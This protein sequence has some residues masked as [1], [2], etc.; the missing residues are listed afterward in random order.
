MARYTIKKPEELTMDILRKRFPLDN[1]TKSTFNPRELFNSRFT[2]KIIMTEII[3]F[4]ESNTVMNS[5]FM[6]NY[7][8]Q[9]QNL[10]GQFLEIALHIDKLYIN[11]NDEDF[12][13]SSLTNCIRQFKN[14]YLVKWCSYAFRF[15]SNEDKLVKNYIGEPSVYGLFN[16]SYM[17]KARDLYKDFGDLLH[18][19]YPKQHSL[20]IP[21][22]NGNIHPTEVLKSLI[23]FEITTKFMKADHIVGPS[24]NTSDIVNNFLHNRK[25]KSQTIARRI[26]ELQQHP[27]TTDILMS[28]QSL[29]N[30]KLVQFNVEYDKRKYDCVDIRKLEPLIDLIPKL[31]DKKKKNESTGKIKILDQAECGYTFEELSN[32][33]FDIAGSAGGVNHIGHELS[34]FINDTNSSSTSSLNYGTLWHGAQSEIPMVDTDSKIPANEMYKHA[35]SRNGC[36]LIWVYDKGVKW[37][38]AIGKHE[39]QNSYKIIKGLGDF[40]K[41]R[42]VYFKRKKK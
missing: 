9:P 38:I 42:E 7:V 40:T 5:Y 41:N 23:L 39:S 35:S 24:F 33:I 14:E 27:R 29:V 28:I 13:D 2:D 20:L 21:I 19:Y 17:N 3:G 10:D 11:I 1:I 18:D 36:T 32:A 6:T 4:R 34:D 26:F 12:D 8:N 25:E 22:N 37:I 30:E 15:S 31:I 16:S